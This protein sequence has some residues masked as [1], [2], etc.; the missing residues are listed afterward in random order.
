MRQLLL[1]AAFALTAS[2]SVS[3]AAIIGDTVT[4]DLTFGNNNLNGGA[5]NV[6]FTGD[7]T[8]TNGPEFD[9]APSP[10]YGLL[11]D[12][13]DT[14]LTVTARD[15][16]TT[17]SQGSVSITGIDATVTGF[18]L[19]ASSPSTNASNIAFTESSLS[20]TINQQGGDRTLVF[21]VA[22][23]SSVIPLPATA[24]LM[25]AGLGGL[26]ALRNRRV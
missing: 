5:F 24:W 23:A 25:L 20:F 17:G 1:G 6:D 4:L 2:V 3:Q 18:S 14:S 8:V 12:L 16:I 7:R 13:S 21:D 22:V 19:A 15:P 9:A 26:A 10:F 11:V